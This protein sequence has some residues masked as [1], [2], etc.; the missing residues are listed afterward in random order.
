MTGMFQSMDLTNNAGMMNQQGQH[1]GIQNH[2][3]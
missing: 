1:S 3:Q 2:M